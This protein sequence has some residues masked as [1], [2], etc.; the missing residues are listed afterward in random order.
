MAD[1]NRLY[2]SEPALHELDSEPAGFE[3]VDANDSN[4]S[5]ASYLR[6]GRTGRPVLVVINYTPLLRSKY[7]VGV[8]SA[9]E[10]RELLNSDAPLYG[11]SGIG[12]LGAVHAQPVASHGR[13]HSLELELPPL[14]A[15]FLK[16]V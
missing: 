12:N 2:R 3:W 6:K 15:L 9:G 4:Q 14:G 5:V 16:P 7:R 8:P 13:E 11:G 10:W 1:L